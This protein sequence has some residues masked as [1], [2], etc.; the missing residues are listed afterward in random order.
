[1]PLGL[2]E[3]RCDND[4]LDGAV[5]RGF[6]QARAQQRRASGR[7]FLAVGHDEVVDLASQAAGVVDSRRGS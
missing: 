7:P 3:V 2:I 4:F 6:G 1:M 5:P